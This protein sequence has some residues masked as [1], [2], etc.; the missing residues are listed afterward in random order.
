MSFVYGRVIRFHETDAA[1]VVYFANLLTLCHEAYEAALAA[2]GVDLQAFFSDADEIAVPI[3]HTEADFYRALRCGD[4]ISVV[5]KPKQLSPHSFEVAYAIW[6]QSAA[7]ES[8]EKPLASALTRHVCINIGDR[9]RRT[10]TPELVD[11]IEAANAPA[12]PDD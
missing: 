9:R 1:G 12:D 4:A 7:T 10:L 3:I 2:A 11:W 8:T 6:P 5:V